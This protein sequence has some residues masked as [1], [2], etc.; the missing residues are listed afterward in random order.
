MPT[1]TPAPIVS[2][3]TVTRN[4]ADMLR[5][6][7]DCFRRQTLAAAE[8]II[9]H[10]SDDAA[11]AA[12]VKTLRGGNIRSVLVLPGI[13]L[14]ALRNIAVSQANARYIAQWDDDDWYAPERLEVQVNALHQSGKQGCVLGRW[15]IYDAVS[16]KAYLSNR[17]PWEGS[18]VADRAALSRYDDTLAQGEDSPVVFALNRRDQLVFI[19]RPDLYVYVF[20]GSNTCDRKHWKKMLKNCDQ[21]PRGEAKRIAEKIR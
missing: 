12:Y 2:C 17:R 14:G 11:T 21:L 15:T 6:A 10:E 5:R 13:K 19:D 4:R 20:H 18:L 16:G 7:V 9:V 3:L 1:P 8:L